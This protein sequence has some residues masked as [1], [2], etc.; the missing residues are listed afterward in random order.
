MVAKWDDGRLSIWAAAQHPFVVRAQLAE[1]FDLALSDVRV[2]V[3]F[4]GGGFGSKSWVHTEPLT[5]LLARETGRPVRLVTDV[6]GSMRTSRRHDMVCRMRTAASADG[7]LLARDVSF[8]MNTGAYADNG[9]RV[10]FTAIEAACS[11]YGWEALR[12]HGSAIYTHT[13]PA[14]S[15][16]GFGAAHLEW[17]GELQID[18]IARQL[19]SDRIAIRRQNLQGRGGMV[20]P[21][22]RAV[23][24]DL[25]GD[26]DRLLAAIGWDDPLGPDEGIGV[27]IG[28]M[29]GGA[30][31]VSAA[32][33]RCDPDGIVNVRVGS[34]EMGQGVRTVMAQIAAEELGAVLGDVRVD[35]ADT[36]S[37]PYDA[38][39]GASRS[40][41]VAGKAVQL[42]AADVAAQLRAFA[43][44]QWEVT[45]DEV[46]LAE[47]VARC[48]GHQLELRGARSLEVWLRRW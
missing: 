10:T 31:P 13:S 28:L 42:A 21:G 27:A 45:P 35:E 32:E 41:T 1:L 14:G 39:T 25:P 5:A 9:P 17:A 19:E 34:T 43:A 48:P 12:S 22:A 15:Y 16:R 8:L 18:A 37:T 3:P 4:L 7:A 11:P 33:V 47:G 26:L 38:S 24:A 36:R 29:P 2:V 30:R 6:S 23:D 44:A 40:T 46:Q 20:R